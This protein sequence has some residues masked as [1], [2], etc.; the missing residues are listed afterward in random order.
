MPKKSNKSEEEEVPMKTY[1]KET[2]AMIAKLDLTETLTRDEMIGQ[3]IVVSMNHAVT[4][5]NSRCCRG[6][7][8]SIK[9][10]LKHYANCYHPDCL[11]CNRFNMIVFEHMLCCEDYRTC[12]IPGCLSIARANGKVPAGCDAEPCSS[13]NGEQPAAPSN[14][15]TPL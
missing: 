5:T 8:F 14:D 3:I 9:I 6:F 13:G 10:I 1:C 7:C 2:A 11:E 4:C 15:E 12:K